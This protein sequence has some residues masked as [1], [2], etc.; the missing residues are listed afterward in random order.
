MWQVPDYPLRR[1][2]E[3]RGPPPT[4]GLPSSDPGA[5][6]RL[7]LR[8]TPVMHLCD[9]GVG[10]GRLLTLGAE[11]AG[12]AV[13]LTELGVLGVGAGVHAGRAAFVVPHVQGARLG[14]AGGQAASHPALPPA[15]GGQQGR[16][17][18]TRALTAELG[19]PPVQ[20]QPPGVGALAG[21]LSEGVA[22][23]A[24][25]VGLAA[26]AE[27]V[28]AGLQV[29]AGIHQEGTAQERLAA[30]HLLADALGQSPDPS[31]SLVWSVPGS[32][33]GM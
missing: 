1:R 12:D 25:A 33:P 23:A 32:A 20:G 11:A 2:G 19:A 21:V 30:Q 8:P 16:A 6:G 18:A 3:G 9:S 15:P 13:V 27:V 31:F 4:T 22:E 26:V 7:R 5:K 28:P 14:C 17:R 24:G 29:A 10:E